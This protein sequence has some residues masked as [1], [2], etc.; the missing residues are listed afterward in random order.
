MI[1]AYDLREPLSFPVS[2]RNNAPLL[3]TPAKMRLPCPEERTHDNSTPSRPHL[4]VHV[5]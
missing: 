1:R 5:L 2:S 4:T 3:H